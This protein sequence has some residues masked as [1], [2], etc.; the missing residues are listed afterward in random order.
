MLVNGSGQISIP[1]GAAGIVLDFAGEVRTA[2]IDAQS[3]DLLIGGQVIDAT[4]ASP[5]PLASISSLA[6]SFTAPG[7]QPAIHIDG[8]Y[9]F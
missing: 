1:L 7:G 6:L 3:L 4:Q 8:N 5:E 9:T 2:R